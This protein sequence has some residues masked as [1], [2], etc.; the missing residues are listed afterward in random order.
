MLLMHPTPQPLRGRP[1]PPLLVQEVVPYFKGLPKDFGLH[2][3]ILELGL[4][5]ST[6]VDCMSVR[7]LRAE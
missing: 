1:I 3:S 4:E 2:A 7:W 5:V 6:A